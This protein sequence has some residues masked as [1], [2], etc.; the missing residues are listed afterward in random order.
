MHTSVAWLVPHIHQL[1]DMWH[2]I[3]T[4]HPLSPEAKA[5][6]LGI[7]KPRQR[8]S[9]RESRRVCRPIHGAL[10]VEA[11]GFSRRQ[12]GQQCP[13][14]LSCCTWGTSEATDPKGTGGKVC[15]VPLHVQLFNM[16]SYL[17]DTEIITFQNCGEHA[18]LPTDPF[19]KAILLAATSI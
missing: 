7:T 12:R 8:G 2:L 18:S 11:D 10:S 1:K 3:S 13:I 17:R 9:W 19:L 16:P 15:I 4:R 5:V 14:V 6:C